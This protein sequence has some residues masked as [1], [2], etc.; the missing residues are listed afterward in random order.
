MNTTILRQ[1]YGRAPL[2]LNRLSADNVAIRSEANN[3]VNVVKR[4]I[5]CG[6]RGTRSKAAAL[7]GVGA[8]LLGFF[9]FAPSAA[10]AVFTTNTIITEDDM[11]YDGEDIVVFDATVTI[12]GPHSFNSLVL[13]NNA[14]LTH[15]PCTT[16]NVHKLE[17]AVSNEIVVSANSRIDVSERGYL[18]GYTTG[19]T[20]VGGALGTAGGSYGGLGDVSMPGA[21]LGAR[22]NAVY[23]DYADPND[24]G[25]GSGVSEA[26]GAP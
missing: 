24:W 7:W 20:T 12:D 6:I 16:T 15:S 11:T 23:G 4:Y 22:V 5:N 21:A 8:L 17:L 10:A 9:K 1:T 13:T 26:L 14:T 19:N 25:S 2:E 18:P 3:Q